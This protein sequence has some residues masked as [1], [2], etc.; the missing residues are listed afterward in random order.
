MKEID[1][2]FA[3]AGKSFVE[4]DENEPS[5]FLAG[6]TPRNIR[7][8]SWR[9]LVLHTLSR[10]NFE[11]Q[12]F[13]PEDPKGGISMEF[14]EQIEWED[15]YLTDAKCIM[16]WIPRD[17]T[18][19]PG[20]TTNIE[21]GRWCDSGKIVV[22]WLPGTPKMRYIEYYTRKLKIPTADTL[23]STVKKAVEMARRRTKSVEELEKIA[24]EA[25]KFFHR[26]TDLNSLWNEDEK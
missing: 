8:P 14:E 6:P 25:E 3:E 5:I 9:P 1:A 21:F 11:G 12:V 23:N 4:V 20:F 10:L 13:V 18:L 17:L 16:F 2:I 24:K 7:V 22:G 15:T 19:L 26:T